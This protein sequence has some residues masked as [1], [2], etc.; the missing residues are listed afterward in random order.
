MC[1]KVIGIPPRDLETRTAHHHHHHLFT[2]YTMS[3]VLSTG[4]VYVNDFNVRLISDS[5]LFGFNC[6]ITL[7][8]RQVAN[9]TVPGFTI[10]I[11]VKPVDLSCMSLSCGWKPEHPGA[12]CKPHTWKP[13]FAPNTLWG[14]GFNHRTSMHETNV[15]TARL[16]NDLL[17]VYMS[18]YYE[19]RKNMPLRETP[20]WKHNI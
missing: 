2:I 14:D 13:R 3:C 16:K 12:S 19:S 18:V 6:Y 17:S 20:F 4:T 9:L 11:C 10:H 15:I 1:W 7:H 5:H 8:S